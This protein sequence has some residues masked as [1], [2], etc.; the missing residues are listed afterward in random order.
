MQSV[1]T[2]NSVR[3]ADLSHQGCVS[4]TMLIFYPTP[5]GGGGCC[6][7]SNVGQFEMPRVSLAQVLQ[8]TYSILA[9]TQETTGAEDHVKQQ[10]K[11]IL[12]SI[13]F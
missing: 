9:V 7:S 1:A 3:R 5:R 10:L 12:S 6:L 11:L 4:Q 8:N 2:I 13:R